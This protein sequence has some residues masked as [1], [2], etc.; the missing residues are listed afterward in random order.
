MTQE[1][2]NV[3]QSTQHQIAGKLH[4]AAGKIKQVVGHAT[5]N[6]DLEAEGIGEK[7]GGKVQSLVG[8]VEKAVGK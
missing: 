6:P 8:R 5:K 7:V 3:K 4:E 2:N 1:D